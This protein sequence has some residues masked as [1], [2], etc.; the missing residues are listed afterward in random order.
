MYKIQVKQG[1][2][3]IDAQK[4]LFN[5]FRSAFQSINYGSSDGYTRHFALLE[6]KRKTLTYPYKRFDVPQVDITIDGTG[7]RIVDLSAMREY[8]IIA[9]HMCKDDALAD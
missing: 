2:E 8:N 6:S 9:Q 4:P 1:A 5:R 3:Y 7:Y